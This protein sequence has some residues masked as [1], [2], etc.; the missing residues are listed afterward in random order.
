MKQSLLRLHELDDVAVALRDLPAGTLVDGVTLTGDLPAGHKVALRGIAVGQPVRKYGQQIGFA[1]AAMAPGDHVHTH[2]LGFG[3]GELALD[4]APGSEARPIEPVPAEQRDTFLGYARPDGRVGTRNYLAVVSTVN[5]SATVCQR[6]AQRFA[7]AEVGEPGFDGVFAVTHKAGCGGKAGWELDLLRRTLAGL[8][9]HP[10]V[11][12]YVLVGLGCEGNTMPEFIETGGLVRLGLPDAPPTPAML[13]QDQ[14]GTQATIEAGVRAVERFLP[15]LRAMR[16]TRQTA[17]KLVVAL[18]CGGSDAWSGITANPA[19]G[20]ASDRV[21][22]QGGIT[23]LGETPEI[24][25]AEHLLTRR[26]VS[27][28]VAE[29]LLHRIAWWRDYTARHEFTI[30]NNPAPGNKVGGLT[31]IYEKSLGAVAKGGTAPLVAVY[32]YAEPCVVPGFGHMDT[33]GYDPVSVTGQVAGGCNLVVFTTGRGSC[34]GFKPAPVLK[35]ASN[36]VMYRRMEPDM[37]LDAGPIAEGTSTVDEVG[38]AI[39]AA[40]LELAGGRASK[41]ETLGVGDEEINPWLLGCTM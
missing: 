37:D 5:C 3:A 12:A 30:D 21:V 7:G 27:P 1:T 2:N 11:G 14:G 18:Q 22:A 28:Q 26:A 29:R 39:Y 32:G 41:S 10:N 40:L 33:P 34:F 38:A 15:E 19:V 17:D 4:H 25:G 36:S 23:V 8:A 9:R 16:R 20:A 6:I 31:T 13:I 35:V 24:Y